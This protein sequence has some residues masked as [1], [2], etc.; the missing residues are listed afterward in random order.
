M[1]LLKAK[2]VPKKY[3]EAGEED[4]QKQ[5]L[6]EKAAKP[7]KLAH[8]IPTT[9]ENSRKYIRFIGFFFR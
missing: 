2:R 9:N 1:E 3:R 5:I 8:S 4:Q 6:R 7:S